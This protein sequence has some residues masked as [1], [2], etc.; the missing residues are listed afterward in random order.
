M[1]EEFE[2]SVML[3]GDKG[4]VALKNTHIAVFGAGGVGGYAIEAL[5][6]A[7][8]GALTI[9][10]N[11]VVS[12]SNINRQIIATQHSVGNKKVAAAK[13][14]VLAINP[15]C[16]V[17]AIDMFYLPSNADEIDLK[18]FDY[19][20]DAIDT[21]SAKIELIVR[22]KASNTKIICAM[23]CANKLD[24][25]RF[26]V[27]DLY[28]TT[29]DPLARVLRRELKKRGVTELAVVFSDEEPLKCGFEK[30]DE[31]NDKETVKIRKH[32]PGSVSFV[33]SV[34]GLVLAGAVIREIIEM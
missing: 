33:P 30:S 2:R 8:V 21:M 11:D 12:K 16:K 29:N 13:E 9:I 1:R 17:N 25:T 10:D 20:I 27:I 7:G 22:A 15:Q 6:R 26:R 14:R 24:P 19:I 4:Q 18:K 23:G 5:A 34:A 3:W 32:I 31:N 28:K